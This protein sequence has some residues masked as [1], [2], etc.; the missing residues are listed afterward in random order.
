MCTFFWCHVLCPCPYEKDCVL[1]VNRIVFWDGIWRH[2][3]A[4]Q[5]P[6]PNSGTACEK[7]QERHG[8]DAAASWGCSCRCLLN[9]MVDLTYVIDSTPC[10]ECKHKCKARYDQRI[11]KERQDEIEKR[12]EEEK[13]QGVNANEARRHETMQK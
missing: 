2:R 10:A 8:P 7:H 9:W 5:A 11:E 4:K 6:V 3:T 12:E 13:K 1:A